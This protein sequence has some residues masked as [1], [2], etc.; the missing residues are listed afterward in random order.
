[1][2]EFSGEK[3]TCIRG[4]RGVFADL[5]FRVA[6]G[7]AL[8]LTGP[9]GSG[10][11]SLLRLMAGL[12]RPAAG[13]LFWE[14]RAIR[15]DYEA[16]RTRLAYVGHLDA[17]KSS[18]TVAENV[19]FWTSLLGTEEGNGSARHEQALSV[20]RLEH[21][22]ELPAHMLS[23]GQRRRLGLSRILCVPVKLWLLD[24]PSVSL[25]ERA[26][27]DLAAAVARHRATGG[28]AV[29]SSHTLLELP[30]A[31]RLDLSSYEF[32]VASFA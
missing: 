6:D 32:D 1:M 22:A 18:L 4:E 12:M 26:V 17:I 9:N 13:A 8:L 31:E 15:E 16:H 19:G 25:D 21:L 28:M 30:D 14:G 27:G 10:K 24:E 7:G 29:V 11:S 3:L 20:F 23:A 2:A 5:S